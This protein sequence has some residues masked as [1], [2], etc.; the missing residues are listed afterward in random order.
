MLDVPHGFTTRAGGV[1]EGAFA[2][3]NV[4]LGTG[5]AEA[6]VKENLARVAALAKVAGRALYTARQVHGDRVVEAAAPAEPGGEGGGVPRPWV[7]ADAVWT[8]RR[9]QAVGVR[10]A[11]CVPLLLLDVRTRRVAAVHAGWRGALARIPQKAVAAWAGLGGRPEDVRAAIGPCIRPCCYE[12][13]DELAAQFAQA[14][15]E[16]AWVQ[17]GA[18]RHLDLPF[19]VRASLAAAG[20]PDSQIDLVGG[21]TACDPGRY[22]SHR[23]DM[24]VTGRHLGFITCAP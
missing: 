17:R 4:G 22:F 6:A 9:G 16:G 5:D 18:R 14:L 7:E 23:R 10:V 3:L 2:S 21:C 11:D 8:F 13:S 19:A 24:G 12:V 15:G 20:V 1:S